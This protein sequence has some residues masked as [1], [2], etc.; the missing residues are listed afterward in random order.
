MRTHPIYQ[1]QLRRGI[2][3]LNLE[4]L[5]DSTVFV[6]GGTGM[7]GACILDLLCFWN[8]E[9]QGNIHLVSSTRDVKTLQGSS[10][11]QA[12]WISWDSVESLVFPPEIP[13]IDYIIHTASNADPVN[14]A[15][16]PV[17]TL[18]GAVAGTGTV[19][20]YAR[21]HQS[22]RVLYLSS[23]EMYGNS[24]IDE[25]GMMMAFEEAYCGTLDHSNP[26]A[27]YPVG[28]RAA[29]V[30]CQSYIRQ[31]ETDVV[32]ARLC[33]IFGPTMKRSDS[34]ASSE[35]LRHGM[36][37][38]PI[39]M[40]SAGLL[41]RSHCYVVDCVVA[42]FLLLERGI[43]GEAY[44]VADAR[45]QMTIREFAE[46]TARCSAV[47]LVFAHPSDM[48]VNGYSQVARAVLTSDKIKKL[49]WNPCTTSGRAIED[50]IKILKD[51]FSQ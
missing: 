51:C 4:K 31:F 6:S 30:L 10:L 50:T 34:R 45:Y 18:W 40:K 26:R 29:E 7:I 15:Q 41:E 22:Q 33:H 17:D 25:Q 23:G 12:Q 44:N 8:Q 43:S 35:F 28:K 21:K 16:F 37:G 47:D 39:V 36:E 20:E 46:Q 9:F 11:A 14:F 19:L 24:E 27:C 38:K 42:L 3:Q 1:E 5:R 32:I 2:A 49:G 13:T 48:E